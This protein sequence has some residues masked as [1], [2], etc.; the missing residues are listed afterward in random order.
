MISLTNTWKKLDDFMTVTEGKTYQL[1]PKS[2][3]KYATS[4]T[5]PA[6]DDGYDVEAMKTVIYEPDGTRYLWLKG[7]AKVYCEEIG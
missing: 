6:D 5:K 1:Q 4:A 7:E 2:C 3:I